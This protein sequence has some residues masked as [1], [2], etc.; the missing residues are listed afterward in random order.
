MDYYL[1]QLINNLA[2][3][4]GWLD[5]LGVFLAANLQYFLVA[6]LLIFLFLGKVKAERIKNYWMVG[7]AFLAAAI[8]RLVFCEIIKLLV[9]RPRPFETHQVIQL[10]PYNT[11]HS[12]PSGH[13]SFFFAIAMVAYLFS[14]LYPESFDRIQDKLRRGVGW[15]FFVGAFLISLA[16]IFVGIH[17]PSDILAGAIIGVFSGWM[18]MK[19]FNKW[20]EKLIEKTP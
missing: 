6:F 7:L 5:A 19:I 15:V 20:K 18:V 17:Y 16:R 3:H 13:A 4:W 12:F 2:G 14:R 10:L 11:G 8:S 9:N 1:F